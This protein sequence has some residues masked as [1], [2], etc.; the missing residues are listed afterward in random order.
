VLV[1]SSKKRQRAAANWWTRTESAYEQTQSACQLLS[2]VSS[3]SPPTHRAAARRQIETAAGTMDA[4][5]NLAVDEASRQATTA[6]ASGLRGVLFA[7][8]ADQLLR[9]GGQ[10]PTGEQLIQSDWALRDRMQTLDSAM[11]ALDV[12]LRNG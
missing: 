1:R 11:K 10:P 12:K 6:V 2:T 5:A 8:E 3:A 7:Q 9:D 4:A